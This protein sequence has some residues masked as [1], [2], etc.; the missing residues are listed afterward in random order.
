MI[1]ADTSV[2][3]NHLRN[4]NDHLASLL[5]EGVVFCHPFIIGELACGNIQNRTQ[6]L[7]LLHDLPQS[8]FVNHEEVFMFIDNKKLMGKGIGYID[9][10]ILASALITDLQLWTYDKKLN[11]IATSLGLS[12]KSG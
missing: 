7:T 1:L 10:C 2:W 8:T 5:N 4:G 9:V 11:N 3:V 6:I 12:Y